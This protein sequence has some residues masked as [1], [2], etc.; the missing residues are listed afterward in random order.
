VTDRGIG[1]SAATQARL[2]QPFVQGGAGTARTFGGTGLGLTISRRLASMM[3]GSIEVESE[4]GKGTR[5]ILTLSLAIADPNE[6]PKTGSRQSHGASVALTRSA[7]TL[8]QAELEKTLVLLADDHPVNRML[9]LRQINALGYAAESANNGVEALEK[10]ESG[11][12]AALI[13]DR[14]MPEMDGYELARRIRKREAESGRQRTPIIACTANALRGEA[15]ACLEAGMDDYLPKPVQLAEL[16]QKL[17]QWLPLPKIAVPDGERPRETLPQSG[18]PY[19]GV[20]DSS[21]LAPMTAG[22]AAAESEILADFQRANDEDAAVLKE[23]VGRNDLVGISR[24]SHRMKG[25]ARMVGMKR[26]AAACERVEDASR[27]NDL[28]AVKRN[29]DALYQELTRAD[30]YISSHATASI[31]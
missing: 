14:N 21:A 17:N 29:L 25:A 16:L 13:T 8:E 3:G 18:D 27:A 22:L 19:A 1:M 28:A 23:A 24:T 10:W 26:L 20:F 11:R 9:L 5:M 31:T 12:F 7:P 4:V 15:E 2:F 30:D 6:L